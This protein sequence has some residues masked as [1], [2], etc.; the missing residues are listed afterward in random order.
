M[1]ELTKINNRIAKLQI[2]RIICG[3]GTV[4]LGTIM[5]GKFIYQ[6]GITDTQLAI[7]REFPDEYDSIT[8]KVIKEFSNE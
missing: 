7:S 3:I 5:I 6:K 2:G 4:I 1:E 8:E